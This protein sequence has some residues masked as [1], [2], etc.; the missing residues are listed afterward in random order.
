MSM[1]ARE[2]LWNWQCLHCLPLLTHGFP[3]ITFSTHLGSIL[4]GSDTLRH[5]LE[6]ATYFGV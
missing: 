4:L 6:H 2:R 1:N 5:H 3:N